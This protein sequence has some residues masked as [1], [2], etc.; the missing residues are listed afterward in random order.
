[1]VFRRSP[2][3]RVSARIGDNEVRS[4]RPRRQ[5]RFPQSAHLHLR[6]RPPVSP[7]YELTEFATTLFLPRQP[8]LVRPEPFEKNILNRHRL[9]PISHDFSFGS[10]P[11]CND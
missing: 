9:P 8:S 5:P 10:F 6:R 11:S 2:H 1:M 7:F 4:C 3:R